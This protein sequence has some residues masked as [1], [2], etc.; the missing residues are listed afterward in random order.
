[1]NE[2]FVIMGRTIKLAFKVLGEGTFRGVTTAVSSSYKWLKE[3]VEIDED[4]N[5]TVKGSEE[6]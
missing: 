2:V 3:S 5:F 4:G 1:M 6:Q